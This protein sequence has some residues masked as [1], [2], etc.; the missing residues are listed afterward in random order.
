MP[1]PHT[2]S[3]PGFQRCSLRVIVPAH[4]V[5]GSHEY[6]M[7][8]E[9]QIAKRNRPQIIIMLVAFPLLC[10]FGV[11][12]LIWL[13]ERDAMMETTNKGTFVDPPVLA[14]E[15]GLTNG[16]GAPV[17]GSGYWWVWLVAADCTAACEQSLQQIGAVR[18]RLQDHGNQ[19]RLA[20]VTPP[21]AGALPSPGLYQEVLRFTSDG[22]KALDPG[23]YLVDPAGNV[24]LEYPV[25]ARSQ[26]ILE[27]LNRLLEVRE[28]A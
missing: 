7:K 12:S 28:D 20:L 24:L 4:R 19:V 22:A 25:D 16:S 6:C 11:F 15:L 18:E 23:I 5:P 9:E 27:D 17:D 8:A 3:L 21:Q 26:P 1:A 2:A 14:W 10:A 13:A